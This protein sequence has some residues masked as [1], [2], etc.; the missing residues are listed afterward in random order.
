M[1]RI[2]CV[3]GIGDPAPDYWKE[4]QEAIE[5]VVGNSNTYDG[6]YWEDVVEGRDAGV[7]A[8]SR[9]LE[10][11]K[12][13]SRR[14][15]ALRLTLQTLIRQNE[16]QLQE[17]APPATRGITPR[18]GIWDYVGDFVKYM[19]DRNIRARVQ[20]RVRSKLL[21]DVASETT[22][23]AHSWGTVVAYDVLHQLAQGRSRFECRNLFTFGSPLWMDPVREILDDGRNHAK[24][25]NTERWINVYNSFDPVGPSVA[26]GLDR[27]FGGSLDR[28]ERV[29][30]LAWNPHGILNYLHDSTVGEILR[31]A[32]RGLG[33]RVFLKAPHVDR[34]AVL[35]GINNYGVRAP[36]LNGCVNDAL[37]IAD[38]LR[39]RYG[40]ENANLRLLTDERATQDAIRE[41][42]EWLVSTARDGDHL[43]F[44]FAG[45]GSQ[46]ADRDGDEVDHL[47]EIICP[48][49]MDWDRPFT[50]DVFASYFNPL[51]PKVRLTAILYAYH[52]GTGLRDIRPNAVDRFLMPP[53]DIRNRVTEGLEDLGPYFSA[54]LRDPRAD[55]PA[56]GPR[57]L[58]RRGNGRAAYHP[59]LIAASKAAE[60]SADILVDRDYH[61]ALTYA[62]V[63]AI[64]A[65]K[66]RI[67]YRQLIQQVRRGVRALGTSQTPQLEG[68]ARRLGLKAFSE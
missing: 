6:A 14:E 12:R 50:D 48:Y 35:V 19:L 15:E 36:K 65:A 39:R 20:E 21:E 57:Q 38:L 43:V 11:P 55:D 17:E 34:K 2:I 44:H 18:G 45:H 54:T 66:G 52:S 5:K 27:L 16:R 64:D 41:R 42:L 53:P 13:P 56:K 7:R 40:F 24:P 58:L 51:P 29:T 9:R 3:H 4:W 47:D 60:T 23:V 67:T 10:R 26:G 62:L 8:L 28:D 59:V 49:D 22:I 46:V 30:F 63:R 32:L 25:T 37:Q 1:G 31:E 33:L 61:G 68:P